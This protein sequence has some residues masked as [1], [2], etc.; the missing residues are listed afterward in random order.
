MLLH[1]RLTLH[2]TVEVFASR[3]RTAWETAQEAME[4][5]SQLGDGYMYM[6]DHYFGALAL[7]HLGEWGTLQ[8]L[9]QRAMVVAERRG[10][11]ALL[12]SSRARLAAVRSLGFRDG[13]SAV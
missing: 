10:T 1:P 9:L 12:V 2:I 4:I 13:E 6:V 3:Y 5:A 11:R 8:D 7:L